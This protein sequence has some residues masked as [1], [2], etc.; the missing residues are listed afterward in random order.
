MKWFV[1]AFVTMI[2]VFSK[3]WAQQDLAAIAKAD[4]ARMNSLCSMMAE[5]KVK[6][7]RLMS[8]I[9][10][11]DFLIK[12][13]SR[14][15][16]LD[17]TTLRSPTEDEILEQQKPLIEARDKVYEK[18]GDSWDLMEHIIEPHMNA[19]AVAVE[20]ELRASVN[21]RDQDCVY[22]RILDLS[23][24]GGRT[25]C[26]D[27]DKAQGLIRWAWQQGKDGSCRIEQ[28]LHNQV[29]CLT[30]R[31]NQIYENHTLEVPSE[32]DGAVL[33][34]I[35]PRLEAFAVFTNTVGALRTNEQVRKKI[36]K[37]LVQAHWGQIKQLSKEASDRSSTEISYEFWFAQVQSEC[38]S[39]M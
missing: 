35:L 9:D 2:F 32:E 31:Y 1:I 27:L 4:Q 23:R 16:I 39:A 15:V 30:D 13:A 25:L 11:Y 26:Q 38:S 7:Q 14:T 3:S 33:D 6:D 10:S 20:Q 37:K 17:G 18:L 12:H 28:R 5:A 34:Y 19:A 22:G 36:V 8:Q 21:Q 24:F 29:T